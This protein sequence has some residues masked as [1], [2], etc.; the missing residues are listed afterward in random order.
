MEKI[1]YLLIIVILSAC[2]SQGKKFAEIKLNLQDT[3]F[4][5]IMNPVDDIYIWDIKV[6][7]VYPNKENEFL[8]K[9]EISSPESVII[10]VGKNRIAS[11]LIPNASIELAEIDSTIVFIGKNAD[12]LNLLNEFERP[13]FDIR[14]G[15]KYQSDTTSSQLEQKITRSK[16][17]ELSKLQSLI[18]SNKIEEKLAATIKEE[19]DYFYALRTQ[20]II[21]DKQYQRI[22]I[23][24]DLIDLFNETHELYPLANEY[25][26]SSWLKYAE[27]NLL[28]KPIY[29]LQADSTIT[30]DS[31]QKWYKDDTWNTIRFKLINEYPNSEIAEKV[32]ADF[33]MTTSKQ[34]HFE[35]SLITCFNDFKTKY[36]NSIYTD[37][38]EPEIQIIEE[39][40]QK[41]SGEM[42]S[43]VEFIDGENFPTFETLLDQ[44]KGDKY[45][46]DIWATW[47]GPCKREFEH[48][49]DLNAL[50]KSKD[51]KK[52][53]ISLDL[54]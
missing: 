14:E 4:V 34:K 36:P 7:T 45:Y 53:Y 47:C 38:L 33:L 39:Y 32:S 37:Y 46:V 15:N 42:P 22:P 41:I 20:Q 24:I 51:Y 19:I 8:Y 50:L 35:K 27:S 40:Y 29:D 3:E 43:S 12:G 23:D 18:D 48:N 9:K 6:D 52:L 31:I 54:T 5:E 16:N 26:S 11:V 28:H 1:F 17:G 2:S 44:I 10:K 21:L 49:D 30:R 25:K 13:Y